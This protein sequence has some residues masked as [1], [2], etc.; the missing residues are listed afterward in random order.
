M[1]LIPMMVSNASLRNLCKHLG[2][3]CRVYIFS[4]PCPGYYPKHFNRGS[5]WPNLFIDFPHCFWGVW[6]G[7]WS[8]WFY[9]KPL[10][11]Y[12]MVSL[13]IICASLEVKPPVGSVSNIF[14]NVRISFML[15]WLDSQLIQTDIP[16]AWRRGISDII[17]DGYIIS[18][19]TNEPGKWYPRSW[20]HM[21]YATIT[22]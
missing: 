7:Y 12:G 10:V 15:R 2:F 17:I 18:E 3:S 20:T 9:S 11:C 16:Y 19:L 22:M 8:A 4:C 13:P 14:Q 21:I 1:D 5:S 6:Q